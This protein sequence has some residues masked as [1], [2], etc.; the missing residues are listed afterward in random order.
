MN[1][2]QFR[3][4]VGF[5][6][7]SFFLVVFVGFFVRFFVFVLLGFFKDKVNFL[8]MLLNVCVSL[9]LLKINELV[10]WWEGLQGGLQL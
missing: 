5:F 6:V 1:T 4:D 3:K 9:L 8:T 10:R 7:V 2:A